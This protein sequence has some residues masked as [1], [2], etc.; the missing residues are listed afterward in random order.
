[1]K[2]DNCNKQATVHLTEIR[3]GKKIEK[4]L[5]EQCAAQ[6]GITIKTQPISQILEELA[7]QSAAGKELSQLKCEHCGISFLEFRQQGLLGCPRDYDCFEA[8]LAPLL[9]RAHESATQ[10]LGKAPR[11]A[12]PE[13]RKQNELL[14][15]RGQLHEA[16]AS[17]QYERAV[18][19]RD[20]IKNLEAL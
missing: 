18:E 12:S 4:H 8:A 5:C 9:E 11:S 19:L 3:N 16:V 7:L 17:E 6:E 10:H 15:L 14:R 1:M 2:C 20:R 13:Q